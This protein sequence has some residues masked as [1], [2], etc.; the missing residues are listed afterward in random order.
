MTEQLLSSFH[1]L[2]SVSFF[3]SPS[4]YLSF[5]II[6]RG[7]MPGAVLFPWRSL[8]LLIYVSTAATQCY[9]PNGDPVDD[10]PCNPDAKSS[11]C[12]GGG[13]YGGTVGIACLSNNMCQGTEGKI[14]RGSCTDPG[15]GEGCPRYCL[16]R[17]K[18]HLADDERKSRLL[19]E[20][21]KSTLWRC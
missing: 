15:F 8:L 5:S 1:F 3:L 2:L 6:S 18:T 16:C 20:F 13:K 9:F 4:T 17:Y 10:F 14:V 12:C 7:T 21:H 11:A 19:M